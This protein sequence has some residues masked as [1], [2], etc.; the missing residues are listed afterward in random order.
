MNSRFASREA[1][2]DWKRIDTLRDEDID[3]TDALEIT[4]EMFVK[5]T[6]WQRASLDVN[7]S[8]PLAT[9]LPREVA[10]DEGDNY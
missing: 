2:T 7:C 1:L 8:H 6:A 10:S 9:H 5:A 4:P 3:L